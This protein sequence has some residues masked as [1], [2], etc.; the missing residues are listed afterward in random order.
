[1]G[2][3]FNAQE[4]RILN[5]KRRYRDLPYDLNP[6]PSAGVADLSQALF[7][8]DYLPKAFA[9]EIL[10]ENNRSYEERLSSCKMI[11]SP[12][13]PTPTVLG[14]LTLGTNPQT[15]VHG[16]YIQFLRLG[17]TELTGEVLDEAAIKGTFKEMLQRVEDKFQAHNRTAVDVTTGATHKVKSLYPLAAVRQILY[18][19]VLHRTYEQTNAP[20]RVYWY[21]D[22]IEISSPGGPY[23]NVTAENF[24]QAGITDYRNPNI[25]DVLKTFGYVQTFG[26]GLSIAKRAMQDNG[27]PPPEFI[28]NSGTIVC[29]LRSS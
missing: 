17:G 12:H 21:D 27:N 8:Y 28:I 23:G 6:V 7:A 14:M 18:N 9:P 16:A 29:I 19:A 1:M 26:R 15:F 20:I 13:E 2:G 22:R 5:E 25:A 11:V 24:G 4:E 3:R 10:A